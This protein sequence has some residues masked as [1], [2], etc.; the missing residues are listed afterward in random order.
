MTPVTGLSRDVTTRF[1]HTDLRMYVPCLHGVPV[2]SENHW[3]SPSIRAHT[4][5]PSALNYWTFL[6]SGHIM[7][8]GYRF[9]PNLKPGWLTMLVLTSAG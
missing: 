8:P 6:L 3:N 2:Y 1:S 9:W 7:A 4:V 5:S